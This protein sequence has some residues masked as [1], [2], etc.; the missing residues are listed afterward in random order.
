M[1][2]KLFPRGYEEVGRLTS[3]A[4]DAI[5]KLIRERDLEREERGET[6]FHKTVARWEHDIFSLL[7]EALDELQNPPEA[8]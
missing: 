3:E 2:T 5:Y 6:P 4:S 7:E 8:P 1:N